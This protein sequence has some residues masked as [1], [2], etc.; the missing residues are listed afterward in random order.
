MSYLDRAGALRPPTQ[1]QQ[2]RPDQV[3]NAAGGYVF[4]L[5]RWA[6]LRRFLVIGTE[7]GTFYVGQSDLTKQSVECVRACLDDDPQ[8]VVREVVDVSERGRAAKN[9]PAILVLAMAAA[10]GADTAKEDQRKGAV[11]REAK[12]RYEALLSVRS[13]ALAMIPRVC[14]TSTHLYQ[15]VEFSTQLRGWGEALAKGV[16]SWYETKSADQLAYQGVKYRQRNGWT[17]RD[18]LRKAH[19]KGLNEAQNRVVQFMLGK[20]EFRS[21]DYEEI[22]HGYLMAQAAPHARAAAE[23]I[24]TF[25]LPREAIK[26]EHLNSVQVWAALLDV[27]MPIGAML[28]NLGTMSKLGLFEHEGYGDLVCQKLMDTA[29]LRKGRVH[30]MSLLVAAKTYASGH[31]FRSD[32]VWPVH[33]PIV[34]ALDAAFYQA[35]E[36]VEPAGMRTMVNIDISGSMNHPVADT[37]LSCR[38]ASTA[39]AL[40]VLA[41]EPVSAAFVFNEGISRSPISPRQRLDDAIRSQPQW[42]GYGA[43]GR[44]DCAQPM[45]AAMRKAMLVDTFV[46]IT[47]NETWF[48]DIHPYKALQQYRAESGIDSRLIVLAMTGSS[49]TI[50]DPR[51]AGMLDVVGFDTAVPEVLR[52][53]SAREM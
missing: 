20:P 29:A 42:R 15:F 3:K 48:G 5:D 18:V 38:E 44:T 45:L 34:D 26:P 10:Y 1:R 53:F 28:R 51:D 40:V 8:R 50:A 27:G 16:A 6:A 9:D 36:A 31:G 2:A 47:D 12:Q 33:A 13:Y 32:A 24:R 21:D 49:Q 23:C 22:L 43:G 14:R 11:D 25:R 46:I 39:L 41:T 19:P 52:A 35:F 17:H 30:P 4:Q 7:G 37:N